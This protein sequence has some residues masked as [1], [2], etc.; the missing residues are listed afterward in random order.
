MKWTFIPADKASDDDFASQDRIRV[1]SFDGWES[2]LSYLD[3]VATWYA[4]QNVREGYDFRIEGFAFKGPRSLDYEH[5]E[6]SFEPS[7]GIARLREHLSTAWG[8]EG[9]LLPAVGDPDVVRCG[10]ITT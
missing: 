7:D 9:A 6:F 4:E 5:V 10:F 8:P 2:G 3:D 1:D